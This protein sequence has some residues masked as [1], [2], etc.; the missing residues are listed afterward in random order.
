LFQGWLHG[1]P[2]QYAHEPGRAPQV[3]EPGAAVFIVGNRYQKRRKILQFQSGVFD[4]L[5]KKPHNF[6]S[7]G[8]AR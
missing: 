6:M 2:I 7:F 4:N 1:N 3:L 5:P 8:A